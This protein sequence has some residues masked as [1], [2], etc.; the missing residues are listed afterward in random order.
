[1]RP[2]H[3]H[4]TKFLCEKCITLFFN[5]NLDWDPMKKLLQ[6][7]MVWDASLQDWSRGK[8]LFIYGPGLLDQIL[9]ETWVLECPQS[10]IDIVADS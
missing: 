6:Q 5:V 2:T 10:I 4:L 8:E 9:N 3:P 7:Y 1:M